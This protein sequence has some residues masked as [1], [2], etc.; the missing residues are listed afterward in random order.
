MKILTKILSVGS[1]SRVTTSNGA[2]SIFDR[3]GTGHSLAYY[4]DTDTGK[5]STAYLVGDL[6]LQKALEAA[7]LY[8]KGLDTSDFVRTFNA[9]NPAQ[10][11]V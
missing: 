6:P 7:R 3:A 9:Q 10:P 2:T 5:T 4:L 1:P 11:L 8:V